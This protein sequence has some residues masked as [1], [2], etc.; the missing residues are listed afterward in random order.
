MIFGMSENVRKTKNDLLDG[1]KPNCPAFNKLVS[2]QQA[3]SLYV[4]PTQSA[5]HLDQ[6]CTKKQTEP[7]GIIL[8]ARMNSLTWWLANLST[9]KH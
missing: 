4:N 6:V 8:G 2:S 7:L 5:C 3:D 9:P 1:L